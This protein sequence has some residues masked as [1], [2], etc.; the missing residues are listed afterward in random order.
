MNRILSELRT[1]R[2][3]M[4]QMPT[5]T[6]KTYLLAAIVKAYV[7]EG[8]R[9]Q[10]LIV[11][12]RRELV[13]QILETCGRFGLSDVVTV[14]SIQW[15][16][17]HREKMIS[18]EER[19]NEKHIKHENVPSLVVI[20]E[21]HHALAKTYRRLWKELPKA[22][23]LGLTATPYRLNGRGF[24]DLFDVLV[25]SYSVREF[26]R[27]RRLSLFDY[28]SIKGD[29]EEQR[30]VDSLTKRG[31]D[32]DYQVKEMGMVLN[33]RPT[34]EK[35]FQAFKKYAEHKK[36]IVYAIDI[37]HARAIADFY[38]EQGVAAV[39]IDS[40]TPNDLRKELLLRFKNSSTCTVEMAIRPF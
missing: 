28:V 27:M 23:F 38:R 16:N 10:I 39:V 36:G 15:L 18:D 37:T 2:A 6:G 8:G 30:L 5:G 4:A 26:I 29:S 22:K 14:K 31:A 21:A 35:L 25:T 1:H 11:A 40:K 33:N 20:D 17:L 3:V 34:I 7:N 24:D 9:R 19:G 32:G 12:H 13:E